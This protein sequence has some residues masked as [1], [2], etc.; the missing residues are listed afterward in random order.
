MTNRTKM[1]TLLSMLAVI[2]LASGT[3]VSAGDD[4]K[5][6][7]E[8]AGRFYEA[9]NTMFTG[10]LEPMKEV[11]S[12]ADDVTYMG[13][14]GGFQVGWKQVLADW[15]AQ[16]DL[17]LGGKVEAVDMQI[18]VGKDIAI[19]QNYEK[20]EN[21]GKDGKVLT[22]LIRATNIFRKEEGVWKMISHH[23]DLLPHLNN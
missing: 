19:I 12:H 16:A 13:P 20:G 5:S 22:V 15:E 9:L 3:T 2:L 7:R 14:V 8:A 4:R 1:M 10:D 17:K 11:W 21:K 18:I 6:A 23:T